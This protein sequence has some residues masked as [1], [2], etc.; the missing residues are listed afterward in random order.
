MVAAPPATSRQVE[1]RSHLRP[2]SPGR[3][4]ISMVPIPN[5]PIVPIS[6]IADTA[7]DAWPTASA[8]AV[9]A[10]THQ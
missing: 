5:M 4:E 10:A 1:I 9:R 3:S 8:G 6:V 2:L 7:A